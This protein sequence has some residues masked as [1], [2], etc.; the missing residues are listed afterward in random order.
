MPINITQP[1]Q[2]VYLWLPP[3]ALYNTTAQLT[4]TN[5]HGEQMSVGTITGVE[6][7]NNSES[8]VP[9]LQTA[10]IQLSALGSSTQGNELVGL[11]ILG[12][13]IILPGTRSRAVC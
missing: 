7:D 13:I 2:T 11:I 6:Y 12:A 1:Q 5:Q 3:S 8:G 9:L 4:A 10:P